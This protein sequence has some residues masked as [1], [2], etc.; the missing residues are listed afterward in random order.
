[1]GNSTG[2][3]DK[4]NTKT[5]PNDKRGTEISRKKEQA[6]WGRIT[7]QLEEINQKVLAKE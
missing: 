7:V 1:M 2:N 4:K 6:T 5:S 3:A